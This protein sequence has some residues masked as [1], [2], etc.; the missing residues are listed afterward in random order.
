MPWL[1]IHVYLW[2]RHQNQSISDLVY[3]LST[4]DLN[5]SQKTSSNSSWECL[6]FLRSRHAQNMSGSCT[7][8]PRLLVTISDDA[9]SLASSGNAPRGD[10]A[11]QPQDP[12][13]SQI[14]RK[15][16]LR[17]FCA[18]QCTAAGGCRGCCTVQWTRCPAPAS[19]LAARAVS[20][21][22]LTAQI[23]FILTQQKCI[24][25]VRQQSVIFRILQY[26]DKKLSRYI[27]I[28]SII[29]VL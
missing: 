28:I 20:A 19:V 29:V 1:T 17:S 10:A 24:Q 25:M 7:P 18:L 13:L 4:R 3:V 5:W 11:S 8:G 26:Q 27:Q 6:S 15:V 16:C 12:R 14:Q 21:R 23:P 22:C 2:K 9:R